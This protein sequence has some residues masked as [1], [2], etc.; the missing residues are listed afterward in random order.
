MVVPLL[1]LPLRRR[2]ESDDDEAEQEEKECSSRVPELGRTFTC[3]VPSGSSFYRG[4]VLFRTLPYGIKQFS[5]L[6]RLPP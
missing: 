5:N 4:A 3:A 2:D 6:R 1:S